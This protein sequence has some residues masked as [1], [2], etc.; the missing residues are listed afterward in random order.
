[1]YEVEYDGNEN[2]TYTLMFNQ[3]PKAEICLGE[4]GAIDI[5]DAIN[6]FLAQ[7]SSEEAGDII[8]I[9]NDDCMLG[10]IVDIWDS[11]QEE[12]IETACFW[13]DDYES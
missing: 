10:V 4:D 13:F 3:I 11:K 5:T 8:I 12:L 1:M 7:Y 2:E 9:H 6:G